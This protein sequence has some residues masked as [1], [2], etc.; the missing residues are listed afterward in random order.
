MQSTPA[1]IAS[2]MT[3]AWSRVGGDLLAPTVG[4]G[5]DRAHLLE[6]EL[7][8]VD[9][10]VLSG[11]AARDHDLDQVGAELE[12]APHRL[13]QLVGPVGLEPPAGPWP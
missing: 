3:P 12:L 11:N 9:R 7:R 5:R 2:E 13:A 4:D 10:L 1:S 6:V 8:G